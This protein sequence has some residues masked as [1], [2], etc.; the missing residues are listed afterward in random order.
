MRL[1]TRERLAEIE[2]GSLMLITTLVGIVLVVA[3]VVYM[4]KPQFQVY[5]QKS[6]RLET[7]ENLIKSQANLQDAIAVERK[8]LE[9]MKFQLHGE[10]GAMPVNE[11]ESYLVGQLQELA[12][13]ADVD[14]AGVRPG[15][16]KKIMGFE[17]ISF[18]VDITGAYRNLYNWLDRISN[19]LGFMLVSNYAINSNGSGKDNNQLN[20]NMTVVFYRLPINE[21]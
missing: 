11:M 3:M 14:L 17:E 8:K 2:P 10:A 5:H 9:E 16:A 1:M 7:L 6:A 13:D 4:I 18:K 20:M 19:K 12:W 15:A 21:L